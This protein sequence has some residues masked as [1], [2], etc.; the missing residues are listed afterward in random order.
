MAGHQVT[1]GAQARNNPFHRAQLVFWLKIDQHIAQ[2]N[3]IRGDAQTAVQ[4]DQIGPA[5]PGAASQFGYDAIYPRRSTRISENLV[6]GEN[7]IS[8]PAQDLAGNIGARDIP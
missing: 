8:G 2:K 4:I 6:L 7:G 3:H 1:S 5:K